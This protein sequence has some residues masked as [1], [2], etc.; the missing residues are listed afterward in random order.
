[1]AINLFDSDRKPEKASTSVVNGTVSNNCDL[2]K[3]GKVLVRIPSLDQEVWAR[4]ASPG[5]GS[6]AGFFYVPRRDD[7]VLVALV[8]NDASDAFII[9]GLWSTQDSP[10]VSDPIQATTKRVIKTGVTSGVGHEVEFDDLSQS[11]TIT[12][13][14]KQQITLDPQKIE[15]STTGGSM[16][17]TL[18]VKTQS[19]SIEAPVSIS[20][21]SK[22]TLKLAGTFVEI[23]GK[24]S[25]K[26]KGK[27]VSINEPGP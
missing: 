5:A 3:Q 17:I 4:M 25:T 15:I 13:S 19:V 22:G 26:I 14:T 21:N 8:G 2:I 24:V 12:T 23:N 10:P 6:G 16:K 18:D 20:I 9:G 27:V 7:E 1:M 11:I